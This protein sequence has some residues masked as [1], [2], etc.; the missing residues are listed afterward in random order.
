MR[1]PTDEDLERSPRIV[2]SCPLAWDP[3]NVVFRSDGAVVASVEAHPEAVPLAL[4]DRVLGLDESRLIESAIS[5]QRHS[6]YTAEEVARKWRISQQVAKQTLE[7]TTQ[8]SVRHSVHPLKRRYRTDTV[9]LGRRRLRC[10]MYTDTVFSKVKSI[11]GHWCAQVFCGEN[12]VKVI[13]LAS[14]A[15]AGDALQEFVSDVGI[16]NEI[17]LDG[18]AEQTG[19]NSE[20]MKKCRQYNITVF[21]TEP[22]TPRQNKAERIG[23]TRRRWRSRMAHR[24]V[25]LRWW[26]F[27]F[28]YEAE[29]MSRTAR[30]PNSRP[31][32]E[33]L[34]GDSV[35]ISEWLDFEFYD[36]VWY[37]HQPGDDNNPRIGRWLGVSH[38]VGSD[39]CY[40]ILPVSGHV[41]ARTTVQH[42]TEI[43][44]LDPTTKQRIEDF[45]T[46]VNRV[47][48]NTNFI[49]HEGA[50]IVP[51]VLDEDW[52]DELV[53]PIDLPDYTEEAFD[54]Y[55][56]AEIFIPSQGELVRGR[57][58]KRLKDPQGNPVGTR[59][60]NPIFDTRD[61][62]AV[63]EDG[64]VRQFSANLVAEYMQSRMEPDGVE[65]QVFREIVDHRKSVSGDDKPVVWL[66]MVE[67][68]DGSATW[69][70]YKQ[71]RIANPV[72]LATYL[73]ANNL[74]DEAPFVEW[75][76]A[77]IRQAERIVAA[78]KKN[79]KKYWRTTHKFGIRL[80]KTVKEALVIDRDTQTNM[81]GDAIDK[82]M[83]NV[84]PAFEVWLGTVEDARSNRHLVGYQE[85]KCHMVFDVKLEN[86]LRKARFVAGGHTTSTPA[87]ITYSSVVA[88]DS[89][90]IAFLLA[91]VDG[92]QVWAADVGNAY[93]NADCREKIWTV[94]G[95]EFGSNEGKVMLIKKALYG[96][97]TSGAAWRAMLAGM[98]SDMGF[99]S[100]RADPDVWIRPQVKKEGFRYHER[101]LIYMDDILC[102]SH[103][104]GAVMKVLQKTYRLKEGSVGPPTR[105]LGADIRRIAWDQTCLGSDGYG[106]GDDCTELHQDGSRES[107]DGIGRG[108]VWQVAQSSTAAV[109]A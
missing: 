77:M 16:P 88:R 25:P 30:G 93:L 26:D 81:W 14:K 52:H 62:E 3:E 10:R 94:A 70:P 11:K 83:R 53:D 103:D 105:Y 73:K 72:E 38:R 49:D 69:I 79:K 40:W 24:S 107:T 106:L 6:S 91:A 2:L 33:I 51:S 68:A 82:E 23:E 99:Q 104:P 7:A 4:V 102:S 19:T 95:P 92:V 57:V 43:E 61:Y 101:V 28:V 84:I 80:P 46:R 71:I 60:E 34:T 5:P 54:E 109:S 76:P 27:G 56:G 97:K 87:S 96:L 48:D 44:Q 85:I 58:T 59:N 41:I 1:T 42:I 90:C 74:I 75:A 22:H 55:V 35:D 50:A 8:F 66:F 39:M 15:Q 37:W 32:I 18:A 98:L 29:I 89:V 13:P 108:R 64:T 36:L 86:L 20:F 100:T 65:H 67:W 47:L 17:L 31:G 9:M 45:T 21:R 63:L 12:Y 78:V